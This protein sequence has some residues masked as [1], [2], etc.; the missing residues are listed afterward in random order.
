MREVRSSVT[1]QTPSL[2]IAACPFFLDFGRRTVSSALDVA[3]WTWLDFEVDAQGH[4]PVVE[5]HCCLDI[6]AA[7]VCLQDMAGNGDV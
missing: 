7:G 2:A 5:Q 1:F 6:G 4:L 3:G